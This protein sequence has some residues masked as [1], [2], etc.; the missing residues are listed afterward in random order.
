MDRHIRGMG[1]CRAEGRPFCQEYPRV[2]LAWLPGIER[3]INLAVRT[4]KLP[5]PVPPPPVRRPD[6]PGFSVLWNEQGIGQAQKPY[7]TGEI[8]LEEGRP[9]LELENPG[10]KRRQP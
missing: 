7:V 3:S 1:R 2:R 6:L 8:T 5:E 10:Q 4:L 9:I